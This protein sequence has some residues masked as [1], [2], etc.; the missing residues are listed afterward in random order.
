MKKKERLDL[1]VQRLFPNLTRNQIQ[2]FIMQGFASVNDRVETKAGRSVSEDD[3]IALNVKEPKYVS[4]AGHKLEQALDHF[5]IDVS[6]L[7]VLDAGIS[8]GG[9]TDC[10][11]QRGAKKVFGIDVGYGQVHE[12][13]A[14]NP[15]VIV[16][17]RTNLRYLKI[18]D[19]GESVDLVTLDLSFISV[20][21]VMDVVDSILKKHGGLVVLIKP[22]FEA[23]K[24][25][26]GKGGIIKDKAVHEKVI[27]KVVSEIQARGFDCKGTIPSATIGSSGNQEFVA[28]FKKEH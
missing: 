17:E 10:L 14:N 2:S 18:E 22:P 23:Q 9:F 12:K 3:Q 19:I 24:S 6:D 1:A 8:T 27:K 7:V 26:V 21:K 28:Y 25:E 5:K 20:L 4:R 16:I 15:K 13:V 11:L